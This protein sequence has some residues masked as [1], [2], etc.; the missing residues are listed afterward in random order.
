LRDRF[1]LPPTA[2]CLGSV[3]AVPLEARNS[4]VEVEYSRRTQNGTNGF[5]ATRVTLPARAAVG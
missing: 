2:D 4:P 3:Q 1:G 5:Y